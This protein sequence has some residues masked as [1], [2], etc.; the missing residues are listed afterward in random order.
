L[1]FSIAETVERH[2][3]DTE[4]PILG[5]EIDSTKGR[6]KQAYLYFLPHLREV[7]F[8]VEGS[9]NAL[10]IE[11]IKHW[12]LHDDM[13]MELG[14]DDPMRAKLTDVSLYRYFND[15]Y[16][17]AISVKP[18]IPLDKKSSLHRDDTTW[19]HD[20]FFADEA[21]FQRIAKRQLHHWLHFTNQARI[22]Y[23]SFIEQ[24]DEDKFTPVTLKTAQEKIEF[25]HKDNISPIV[26]YL[27]KRFFFNADEKQLRERLDYLPNDRM[28]VSPAYGLAGQSLKPADMKRLFSLALYVDRASDTYDGLDG[29]AYE[30]K[31]VNELLEKDSLGRW[32]GLGNYSGCCGYAN[33]YLGFGG[34]FNNVIAPSHIPYIYGR[35]LTL[36]LFYQMALRHYNR[37]INYATKQLSEDE[38]TTE[39]QRLRKQFI[40]FTNSY[41]FR[42]VTSQV[43]GIEIFNLQTQA[44]ELEAEYSLIK[45]EME[46]ADEYSN[47]LRSEESAKRSEEL[48]KQVHKLTKISV[49]LAAVALVVSAVA[50]LVAVVEAIS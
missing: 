43:Q 18:D 30:P 37:R 24:I 40:R 9:K 23:P 19:W 15:T 21:E 11:P 39:F 50:L 26:L 35:M 41:W 31:F 5:D 17:L 42:E 10:D 12:R 25:K 13:T 22:V 16:L 36:A 44:L 1:P 45:D 7:I 14:Q 33:A 46:R 6:E 27:L 2:Y 32:I 49:R 34:F 48:D 38:K 20:L 4:T 28:V 47:A 8:D 3:L 29:Y